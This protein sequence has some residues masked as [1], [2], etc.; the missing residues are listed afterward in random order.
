ML[1]TKFG[2]IS[3]QSRLMLDGWKY[4]KKITIPANSIDEDMVNFP[5]TVYLNGN[6]IYDYTEDLCIGG[7]AISG[8]T[9]SGSSPINA[10]DNLSGT[11][12]QSSQVDVGNVINKAY[13][14]YDFVIPK[15]IRKIKF[16]YAVSTSAGNPDSIKLQSSDD[17]AIWVDIQLLTPSKT[18]TAVQTFEIISSSPKRYWRCLASGNIDNGYYFKVAE[19]EMMEYQLIIPA[20]FNFS[21]CK[22]DGSDIRFTDKNLNF[23]KFERKEHIP[24]EYSVDLCTNGTPISSASGASDPP[25]KAYDNVETTTFWRSATSYSLLSGNAYIGYQFSEPREIRR[26]RLVPYGSTNSLSSHIIQYS[27]N[28]TNWTSVYTW[29]TSTTVASIVNLDSFGTHS[30]WR[31]LAN[32]NLT[33]GYDWRVLEIEMMEPIAYQATYNILIPKVSSLTDTEFYMWFGNENTYNTSIEAWQDQTGKPITYNGNVKLVPNV[34]KFGKAGYFDGSGDYI[35]IPVHTDFNVGNSDF[36][37]DITLRRATIGTLQSFIGQCNS[38]LTVSTISYIIEFNANNTITA[39]VRQG[40]TAYLIT[41][42]ATYTDI[43]KNYDIALERYNNILTLFVDGDSVGSVNVAGV[44]IN[45]SSYALSIGRSGEYNGNYFNGYIDEL[46]LSNIARHMGNY[47]TETKPY[48]VDKYTKLL[49]HFDGG[50]T[51]YMYKRGDEF[52]DFTGGIKVMPAF[53]EGSWGLGTVTKNGNNYTIT[54]STNNTQ[55]GITTN[56]KINLTPYAKLKIKYDSTTTGLRRV[57]FN[58]INTDNTTA[59]LVALPQISGTD[60]I[61]EVDIS[62]YSGEYYIIFS[63]CNAGTTITSTVKEM[64]LETLFKDEAGKSLTTYGNVK[65]VK[66][67]HA[68]GARSAHF[69]GN[70]DYFTLTDSDDWNFG[71]GDFKIS[72]KVTNQATYGTI[73][74]QYTGTNS[75]STF[76]FEINSSKLAKLYVYAGGTAY[77]VGGVSGC[78]VDSNL[79]DIEVGR[80]GSYLYLSIDGVV[81]HSTSIGSIVLNN[82]SASIMIGQNGNNSSLFTGYIL[83]VRVEKG[84]APHT[85]NFTPPNKFEIDGPDVVFCT[86]FDTIYDQNY[87]MIQHMG[88]TLVD[89]TGN[90]NN[91][92]A[93][94]TTIINTEF[95]KARSFNGTNSTVNFGTGIANFERTDTFTLLTV[96]KLNELNKFVTPFS[97]MI[98][99]SPYN[100]WAIDIRDTNTFEF[101]LRNNYTANLLRVNTVATLTQN[102]TYVSAV[103]Y[104]GSSNAN[105]AKLFLDSALQGKIV[106]ANTLTSSPTSTASIHVGSQ[107]N[108]GNYFSGVVGETRISTAQRSDAWIKAESLSLKN[109]LLTMS[110]V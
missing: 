11:Y 89:A 82:S 16:Q 38:G 77:T 55:A 91:G 103:S 41:T 13:I 88:D 92:T 7:T 5:C 108:S 87:A 49:I 79:H 22:P 33:S 65:P 10:F 80:S 78:E 45:S 62:S 93:T 109:N 32:A 56:N 70:G 43:N 61:H 107:N 23:L 57:I 85:T 69:D 50:D 53:T 25:S 36:C 83:G 97:K 35:S 2:S 44:T 71:S 46:R 110:N 64:W 3:S 18:S 14:G 81:K 48:T 66:T 29:V 19:I 102:V 40:S 6:D 99:V 39:Q 67:A 37:I 1:L 59:T 86:N 96:L 74:A 104:D 105:N 8:G 12:W 52:V 4:G 90:G 101:L 72:A 98:N 47:I 106:V 58:D 42:S 100:G 30:Y 68:D 9:Y 54:S 73:L 95:G 76:A 94:G 24:S 15:H 75:T 17:G 31:L 20:N 51:S 60:I 21:Q 84:S 63:N 26:I 28:G 27:D 34:A